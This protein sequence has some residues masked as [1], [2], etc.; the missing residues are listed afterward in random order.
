MSVGGYN[1]DDFGGKT[2]SHQRT[3]KI[4]SERLKKKS[5][6]ETRHLC[7]LHSKMTLLLRF[8]KQI[9]L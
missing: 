9:H 6:N 3:T 4:S 5:K 7:G 8:K 2:H 1:F